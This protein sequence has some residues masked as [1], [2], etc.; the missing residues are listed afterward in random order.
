MN[1]VPKVS[2]I[3][4]IFNAEATLERC[5][6]SLAT[7]TLKDIEIIL[8]DDGSADSSW[9]ICK[10][11]QSRDSRFKIFHQDNKGVSQARQHGMDV[12]IG[13]YIIYLDSD[14]Y[15]LPDAYEAFYQRAVEM[16]ADI[17]YSDFIRNRND[18]CYRVDSSIPNCTEKKMLVDT[19]YNNR[20]Y[21]WNHLFRKSVINKFEVEFPARMQF[22]EDQY[23]LI[24]LLSKSIRLQ[25]PLI[26][27][28]LDKATICYDMTANTES[29]T[30]LKAY[31][32]SAAKYRWWER[33]GNLIDKGIVGKSYYSVLV[34]DAF[35]AFWNRIL[36]KDEF[37]Q[38]YG[39][40]SRDIQKY[41][42]TNGRTFLVLL[43]S[44]GHYDLAQ[45]LRWICYPS[46][47]YDKIQ[48]RKSIKTQRVRYKY[49]A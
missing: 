3:V 31:E 10:Q 30:S 18:A 6:H 4:T 45:R 17:V 34:N 40:H 12:A 48:Q 32:K 21:V 39:V 2:I 8:I 19:I 49:P 24:N 38:R 44:K 20:G 37:R 33:I 1:S 13:E 26:I 46:I 25:Y 7:Q 43:A 28:F 16:N 9:S 41:T 14:D 22:G 15:A 47:L 23:F 35:Y 29:L 27:A 42:A 36:S 11:Y 5:L